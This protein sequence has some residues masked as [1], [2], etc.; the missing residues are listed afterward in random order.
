MVEDKVPES[1]WRQSA[2][3]RS[4]RRL[5]R[6]APEKEDLG[7]PLGL[8]VT[9]DCVVLARFDRLDG[10]GVA[11]GTR[12]WTWRP[13]GQDVVGV[14]SAVVEDDVGVVLHYDDGTREAAHVCLTALDPASG[15]VVWSRKEERDRLGH[16]GR[17][18]GQ[19]ALGTGRLATVTGNWST[20]PRLRVD[21]A[22]T[23]RTRWHG[24]LDDERSEV[25]AVVGTMPLVARLEARGAR[26][27]PRLRVHETTVEPPPAYAEF[28]RHV[29]VT[30]DVLVAELVPR[31]EQERE[32]HITLGGFSVTTGEP[33]WDWRV[34]CGSSGVFPLARGGWLPALHHYGERLS[35]LDPADGR[36]VG[37][38]RLGGGWAFSPLLA[39]H[40]DVI[41]VACTSSGQARRLRV[42][43]RR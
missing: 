37:E 21:D 24:A 8:W 19:V 31:D 38:H 41:A 22:R 4:T 20:A 42:F 34:R 10:Y 14:V 3:R 2:W 17:H 5:W 33:L 36:L 12:L 7:T 43:R 27:R 9:D 32:K 6:S 39:A 18:N 13:P 28:G 26:G 35:V 40:G 11:T 30:G 1:A 29:A 15:T 25:G 16:M 23:G